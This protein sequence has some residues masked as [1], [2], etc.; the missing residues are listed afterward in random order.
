MNT[1][2]KDWYM[3]VCVC[4]TDNNLIGLIIQKDI[5]AFDIPVNVPVTMD[6]FQTSRNLNNESS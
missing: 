3:T 5:V 6:F 1:S 4:L 2:K